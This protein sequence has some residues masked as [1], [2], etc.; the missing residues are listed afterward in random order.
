M[1]GNEWR[2]DLRKEDCVHLAPN[3]LPEASIYDQFIFIAIVSSRHYVIE[4]VTIFVV[5]KSIRFYVNSTNEFF[6]IL[7]KSVYDCS[8][9]SL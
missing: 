9:D 3:F 6:A 7:L 2:H 8:C 1:K 4:I 5:D